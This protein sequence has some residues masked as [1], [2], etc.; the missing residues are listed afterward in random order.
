MPKINPEILIWAREA[1]KMDADY[2]SNKLFSDSIKKTAIEK[3]NECEQG[4]FDPSRALLKRMS[5]LYKQSLLTFYL[6][7]PPIIADRGVD[8]RTFINGH[9]ASDD[10]YIDTMIKDLQASQGLLKSALMDDEQEAIDFI[11]SVSVLDGVNKVVQK[12]YSV[13]EFSIE[14]YRNEKDSY[15]AF[16][17]LRDK[18]EASGVFVLLMGDLGSFHSVIDAEYFRGFA[19][20][21]DIAPFI[22]VN[23][24]DFKA[25]WSFTLMHE[26]CHILLGQTGISGEYSDDEIE[27]FCDKAASEFLL[28]DSDVSKLLVSDNYNDAFHQIKEFSDE[29][30][31]S[32]T[33]VAYRLLIDGKITRDDWKKFK[34]GFKSF[35]GK[36]RR[37]E[38]EKMAETTSSPS[39]YTLRKQRLGKTF[40]KSVSS[41]LND[42][43]I[44]TTKAARILGVSPKSIDKVLS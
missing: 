17:L 42:N 5:A 43:I 9:S 26:F 3:L 37:K 13:L 40:R 39:Y 32:M 4:E 10:F 38:K 33:M 15:A 21:D 6:S 7:E 36:Q 19:L 27:K 35:W 22:I 24:N 1:A 30:K 25:S 11:G 2:A 12:M 41:L 28:P 34:D 16:S 8:F 44:T 23:K 29:R 20:A 31:V 14:E 18:I